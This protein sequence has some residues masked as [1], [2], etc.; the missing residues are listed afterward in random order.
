MA[1]ASDTAGPVINVQDYG[2][3]GDGVS[4]DTLAFHAASQALQEAGGGTLVIPRGTYIVGLQT[5]GLTPDHPN[6]GYRNTAVP[7]WKQHPIIE[8]RNVDGVVIEG[9]GA[10]L[11]VADGL[12]YGGYDSVTGEPI[13]ETPEPNVFNPQLAAAIGSLITINQSSHIII[14]DLELDGNVDKQDIGGIWSSHGRQL[15]ASGIQLYNNRFVRIENIHTHHHALDGIIIGWTN[16]TVDDPPTPH[17][18]VNI[19]SEYN[20]R[21]GLSWVGGRGLT[22]INCKFNHTGRAVF[23]SPPG[24]GIDIE[25]EVSVCRDG[26]F[27]NCQFINNNGCAIVADSG[28]GGYTEFINCTIWG[29]TMWSVW[30]S[31]PGLKFEDCT[32]HG[33]I[34][35]G[36]GSDDPDLATQYRRC[37]FEDVDYQDKGCYRSTALVIHSGD[38]VLF[39]DCAIIANKTKACYVDYPNHEIFRRC[40]ITHRWT[41]A[42]DHTFQ[43]IFRGS[44]LEEV[45]FF[46]SFDPA[47]ADKRFSIIADGVTIGAG[48]HVAGPQTKWGNWSWG[49]VGDVPPTSNVD[50]P[51]DPEL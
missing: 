15:P 2:A 43:S 50:T 25:P 37:H 5:H 31:K 48:N 49:S 45:S 46:E 34:V 9:N 30:A 3:R 14:R 51:A 16:L 12:H 10:T 11:R 36:V 4:N 44:H 21:Q 28:D 1:R 38:N 29:T 13:T 7:Y 41:D 17:V 42:P 22:A 20:C 6:P 40:R 23:G 39:E 27:V 33:S 24:A 35:H 18:L 19:D 26:R 47:S 32:I 8:L